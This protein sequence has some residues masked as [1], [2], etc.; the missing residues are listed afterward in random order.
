MD[1]LLLMIKNKNPITKEKQKY[2]CPRYYFGF[3]S[4]K[5]LDICIAGH[6]ERNSLINAAR[7][8]IKTKGLKM[9]MNCSIPCGD[10]LIEIINAG[11]EEIICIDE[12]YYDEKSKYLLKHS[13]LKVRYF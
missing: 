1:L 3:E 10:C 4:G 13:N 2:T 11:I 6:A 8:G 5:G 12:T 9:Y 7:V